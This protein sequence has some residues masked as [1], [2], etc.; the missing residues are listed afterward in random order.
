MAGG[1]RHSANETEILFTDRF[2]NREPALISFAG[3]EGRGKPDFRHPFQTSFV[4]RLHA[5]LS[6]GA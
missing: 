2:A 1:F 5:D 6:G 4:F 3:G